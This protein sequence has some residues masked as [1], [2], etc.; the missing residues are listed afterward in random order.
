[1]GLYQNVTVALKVK[2]TNKSSAYIEKQL[3][4]A[5]IST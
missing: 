1:M 3:V 2:T 5:R 4:V